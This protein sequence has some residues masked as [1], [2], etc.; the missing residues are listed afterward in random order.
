MSAAT[1][2]VQ[3]LTRRFGGLEAVSEL[4]FEVPDGRVTSLIGPNGAGKTTVFNVI[5]GVLPPSAGRVRL[6]GTDV[7]G[8]QPH[9]I[10]ALG[11]ARTFQNIQL[12]PNLNALENVMVARYCRTR[13]NLFD[14]VF[15]LKRDRAD[16]R[17]MLERANELLD[18][19]GLFE[20]RLLLPRELPYGD[21][22]R[23][24]IARALASE[25]RLLILDE[26]TAGMVAREAHAII[27]LIGRLTGSGI[28]LLLIEHNMNV[29]MSVSDQIV[30]LNFGKKIAEG[31]PAEVQQHPEVI[32]AY[33]G[34]DE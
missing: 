5:S 18:F 11:M 29:V 19:V 7:T 34:R 4:T 8:W 25:P 12:F 31:T 15:W 30:V 14:A 2:D 6:G 10:V 32:E 23:L 26:P 27:D 13:S 22:R 17:Q 28:T 33:L 24:E 20:R 3:G 16:R 1:L 21:Q 9:R